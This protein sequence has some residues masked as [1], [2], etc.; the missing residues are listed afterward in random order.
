MSGRIFLAT[1]SEYSWC[2]SSVFPLASS[3]LFYNGLLPFINVGVMLLSTYRKIMQRLYASME[4]SFTY[5]ATSVS[6]I[7]LQ[8]VR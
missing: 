4:V 7:Y 5:W 8:K 6:L 3:V 2:F 1:A